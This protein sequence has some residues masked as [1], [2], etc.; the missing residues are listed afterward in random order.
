VAASNSVEPHA[1]SS[2]PE[3][4]PLPLGSADRPKTV[5]VDHSRAASQFNRVR[6]GTCELR[7]RELTVGAV[8]RSR[9][10]LDEVIGRGGD[11]VVFRAQDLHRARPE[12]RAGGAIAIKALLPGQRANPN[13]LTRLKREFWQMQSLT[14]AG[15]A[16]VFDLDRENDIWF[17][18]MELV[19]GQTLN[20]WMQRTVSDAKCLEVIAGCCEAL[21]YAHALGVLHGDLKPSNVLIC[22]DGGVKLID[23]GSAPRL[24]AVLGAGVDPSVAAT[25]PYASP[26]MLAGEDPEPR[27]DIFSLACVSYAVLSR[28]GHPFGRKSSLEAFRAQMYPT[29]VATIPLR[30]FEVLA[31]GLAPERAQ[32]QASVRDFLNELVGSDLSRCVVAASEPPASHP[33]PPRTG[34]ENA[35]T[36]EAAKAPSAQSES[37]Q[38]A[39]QASIGAT[40]MQQR[41]DVTP[42]P[43]DRSQPVATRS[44]ARQRAAPIALHAR[45]RGR[46]SSSPAWRTV[47]RIGLTGVT[48]VIIIT[49]VVATVVLGRQAMRP[50][51][52]VSSEASQA[53]PA[54]VPD[55]AM[56]AAASDAALASPE[57]AVDSQLLAGL[58]P[59]PRGSGAIT[60]ES[61]AIY[62]EAAQS[63][64][65]IPLKRLPSTRGRAVVTWT[66]E[67]GTAQPYVDYEPVDHQL[68]KF[69]EGQ[70]VRSLFIRLSSSGTMAPARGPRT[71]NVALQRVGRGP[72]IGPIARITVTI[73]SR[74]NE[75][76]YTAARN[77]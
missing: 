5:R 44:A 41:I 9:Y 61:S 26:Q 54:G 40:P 49:G 1:S 39:A 45:G 62:A 77:R 3:Q 30:I 66:T 33:E 19:A 75:N 55:S 17:M 43:L 29:H 70:A 12:E 10:V 20:A 23:F 11:S 58:P 63:L 51:I 59:A 64:I 60:F 69:I 36:A 7:E 47:L 21:A 2:L 46:D 22:R 72:A 56:A 16:R 76:G 74:P 25:A 48:A 4:S 71:V 52:A 34:Y 42:L 14:H 50:S 6:T 53:E 37:T 38:D 15:I 35:S 27:D 67:G 32:R 31:R 68:A 73:G 18:S 13:A 8:L 65:A 57:A 24:G 28:G